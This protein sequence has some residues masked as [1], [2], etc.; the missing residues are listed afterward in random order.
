MSRLVF[1]SIMACDFEE[2]I[3]LK[4]NLGYKYATEEYVLRAFDTF[5]VKTV[6]HTKTPQDE[7]RRIHGTYL[8]GRRDWEDPLRL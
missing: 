5:L 1:R 7:S 4:R 8:H 2:F 3:R 6:L